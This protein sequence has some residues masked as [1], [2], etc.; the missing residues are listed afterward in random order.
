MG[1]FRIGGRLVL[2]FGKSGITGNLGER[3]WI[4]RHTSLRSSVGQ[5]EIEVLF[6]AIPEGSVAV[7]EGDVGQ[8]RWNSSGPSDIKGLQL[9]KGRVSFSPIRPL[10][11]PLVFFFSWNRTFYSSFDGKVIWISKFLFGPCFYLCFLITLKFFTRKASWLPPF[12]PNLIMLY[13]GEDE[14][15][16]WAPCPHFLN[17]DFFDDL[18]FLALLLLNFAWTCNLSWSKFVPSVYQIMW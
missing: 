13:L 3:W 9:F 11:G 1:G 12:L 10:R 15:L 17:P 7:K 5:K 16:V 6:Q 8:R 18:I 2:Q 14:S 4:I